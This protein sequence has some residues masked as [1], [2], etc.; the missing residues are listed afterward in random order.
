MFIVD[1]SKIEK[2]SWILLLGERNL[3]V[4]DGLLVVLPML[5]EENPEVEIRLEV[6]RVYIQS[7]LIEW[8]DLVKDRRKR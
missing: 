8:Q 4:V 1:D 5:I 7:S 6:F 2:S 3:Q